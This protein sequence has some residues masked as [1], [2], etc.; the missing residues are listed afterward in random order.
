M[1]TFIETLSLRPGHCHRA[2]VTGLNLGGCWR[3]QG[4]DGGRKLEVGMALAGECRRML[5]LR[6]EE[7]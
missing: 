3:N 2:L 4:K 7:E 5:A 1:S 6:F